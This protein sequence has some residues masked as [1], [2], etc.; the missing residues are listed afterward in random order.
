M[1]T[2]IKNRGLCLIA[3]IGELWAKLNYSS[4]TGK[5]TKSPCQYQNQ[6]KEEPSSECIKCRG[7]MWIQFLV[8]TETINCWPY[9]HTL[10]ISPS[11]DKLLNNC[12]LMNLWG[13][14]FSRTFSP[15]TTQHGRSS[16]V[17]SQV[18]N[19][20]ENIWNSYIWCLWAMQLSNYPRCNEK[21]FAPRSA[22]CIFLHKKHWLIRIEVLSWQAKSCLV[23]C[24]LQF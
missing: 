7:W 16:Q 3:C 5:C 22:I 23:F 1:Y 2:Q 14:R 9:N 15:S 8:S 10:F 17:T 24:V 4:T 11:N 12:A 20:Q 19:P 6:S 18:S 13:R 21:L